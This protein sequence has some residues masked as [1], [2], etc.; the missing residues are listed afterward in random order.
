MDAGEFS[1]RRL[2]TGLR[3]DY[4]LRVWA[5]TSASRDISAVAE[6]VVL[7]RRHF[8]VAK[9]SII[10]F[11]GRV[12]L[13]LEAQRPIVIRL[14]RGL[15]VGLSSALWKN[16]G[17]DPDAIWHHRVGRVQGSGRGLGISP[18][19]GVLLGANLGCAI[20]TNGD[21]TAYVSDSAAMRPSSQL[22]LD[23]LVY[24][25]IIDIVDWRGV[26]RSLASL[27]RLLNK[28]SPVME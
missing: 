9:Q 4:R 18:R 10:L 14:S 11:L 13:A 1:G 12:A 7:F 23:R 27:Y 19:E 15:C 17:S 6:P 24:C 8:V 2:Y 20:A 22:T 26:Y 3:L 5:S 21:F 25:V 16:G 28:A